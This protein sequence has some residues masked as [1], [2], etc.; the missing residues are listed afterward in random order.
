[1]TVRDLMDIL[2]EFDEDA[3]VVLPVANCDF[4]TVINVTEVKAHGED[5]AYLT[6]CYDED[7]EDAEEAWGPVRDAVVID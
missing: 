6:M 1:M 3:V 4:R 5:D 2:D 7:D